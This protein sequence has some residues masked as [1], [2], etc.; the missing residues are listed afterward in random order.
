MENLQV[1]INQ[2]AGRINFNFEEMKA[3]LM[4]RLEEYRG[5]VFTD[6][7]IV[8]AK[9]YVASLRKE[10]AEFKGRVSE[11]RKEY[12]KPFEQFKE[13]ADELIRLYDEPINFINGQVND[14]DQRRKVD[15]RAEIQNIFDELQDDIK[16]Y[17]TL[18]KIYNPKWENATYKIKDVI[19]DISEIAVSVR[20]DVATIK[21]MKS[22]AVE[23]ALELYKANRNL[24]DAISYITSYEQQKI[25]IIRR[26]EEKRRQEEEERIRRE[27][28]EKIAAEMKMAEIEKRAEE[29]KRA[30]AEQATAEAIEGFIPDISGESNLYEYRM[31]LTSDAK[32][33]LEMF[34]DSI[35]IEWE[36]I[37]E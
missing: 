32:C 37:N 31:S 15:K 25:E 16:E 5:A 7:S 3:F 6:D 35:G 1:L 14:F 30:A 19:N 4:D 28:R 18:E 34:L 10:Q 11:V 29:E 24:S 27:E 26:E 9:K 23:S 13:K 21:G 20:N 12:M 2:E 17:I 8:A 33:K 22:D 36:L